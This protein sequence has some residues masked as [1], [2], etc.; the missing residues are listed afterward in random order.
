M[1]DRLLGAII[2]GT[3][4]PG[5]RLTQEELAD[6][7]GVSRQPV[8]H[9]IQVLRRRGLFVDAGKRGVAVAPIDARRI[10]LTRCAALDGVAAELMA[11]RFRDW[12][13]CPR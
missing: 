1:H 9:A 5:R 11:A 2:D 3:L 8:S 13:A 7:L 6:M 10:H 4:E 12:H